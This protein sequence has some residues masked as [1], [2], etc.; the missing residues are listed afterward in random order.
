M[1]R[2]GLRVLIPAVA[3]LLVVAAGYGAGSY[4]RLNEC[5]WFAGLAFLVGMILAL[6][7]C[8]RRLATVGQRL[9]AVAFIACIVAAIVCEALLFVQDARELFVSIFWLF[10]LVVGGTVL[11]QRGAWLVAEGCWAMLFGGV[12]ALAYNVSH[13]ES[14]VS[15]FLKWVS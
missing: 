12:A 15:F 4:L 3:Q 7:A 11:P 13:M 2:L 6:A 14:G 10:P 9:V 1:S 8:C 5:S